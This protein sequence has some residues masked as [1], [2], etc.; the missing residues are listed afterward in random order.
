MWDLDT[1][2]EQ[3]WE[4]PKGFCNALIFYRDGSLFLLRAETED[5][6]DRPYGRTD[7]KLHPRVC[8]L[9]LLEPDKRKPEIATI[10][11]FNRSL[12]GIWAAPD[13]NTF[14]IAGSHKGPDGERRTFRA[15]DARTGAQKWS[16]GPWSDLDRTCSLTLE[17]SGRVVAFSPDSSKWELND[18]LD[19]ATGERLER[20][21][22]NFASLAPGARQRFINGPLDTFGEA[23]G[24]SLVH[25]GEKN[26]LL[27]LGAEGGSD[28]LLPGVFSPDGGHMAQGHKDGTVTLMKLPQVQR[29]LAAIGLGW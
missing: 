9:R 14:L 17:P 2:K 16:K 10:R 18:L 29:N 13:G 4:L 6:K 3:S 12:H 20:F 24:W 19:L 28:P 26:P 23:Q 22:E 5:G 21:S 15:Y 27:V 1:G 7:F 8:R 11:E 25:R